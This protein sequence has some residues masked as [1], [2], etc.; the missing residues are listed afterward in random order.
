VQPVDRRAF[1]KVAI[2]QPYF[3]PYIGYFQLI[4]ASDVFVL[5]DDV[6]Y[7]SGGW[8]NRN[9]ILLGGDDR[10]ITLPVEKASHALNI[11]ARSYVDDKRARQHIVNQLRQAYAK[12]PF[13]RQ[14]LPLVE[15]LLSFKDRNVAHFNA[16]LIRHLCDFIGMRTRI[17]VSSDLDKD[18]G[19]AGEARVLDICTRLGATDY[20]NPIGGTALYHEQAFRAAGIRLHFLAPEERRYRQHGDVW[21]PFLSII[22][23]LMFNSL[24]EVRYLLAAYRLLTH[25]EIED[26]R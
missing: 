17:V 4:G 20:C 5:H 19:L 3:F 12:A 15:E 9:R 2:M 23:V 1:V 8:V 14:V 25:A 21:L 6:Q 16:N 18:D 7:I 24:E 10:M 26:P 11:D 22:D 13:G